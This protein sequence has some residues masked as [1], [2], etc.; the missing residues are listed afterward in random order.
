MRT[1]PAV[2]CIVV[3]GLPGSGKTTVAHQ[4]A[5]AL[6]GGGLR[7]EVL[8]KDDVLEELFSR[9]PV[10]DESDRRRLSR[11][12]DDRFMRR[13]DHEPH[14]LFVSW[15]RHPRSTDDS[16]TPVGWFPRI[17]TSV[18][19]LH[20][21]CAPEIAAERFLSRR[22]HPGHRDATRSPE[23][24]LHTL[25]RY[26]ALGPL[27]VGPVVE[28]VTDGEVDLEATAEALQSALTT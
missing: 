5:I 17:R 7:W 9:E 21:R 24:V 18:V 6:E 19:E 3:S 16:G 11:L 8:D 23:E 4:L 25:E 26:A 22:R 1:R 15:W 20:C 28:V 12:A 14:G 27:G 13:M 2:G 10:V